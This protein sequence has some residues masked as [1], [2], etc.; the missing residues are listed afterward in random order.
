[1]AYLVSGAKD[2]EIRLWAFNGNNQ[3]NERIW[4][5]AVLQGHT[6]NLC[7]VAFAPKHG[8]SI[9]SA[10]QDNTVK[11]WGLDD[12]DLNPS[13]F[14]KSKAS[15][16]QTITQASLT[17]MA[18]KKFINVVKY[19][20]N[21]KIIASASQDKTVKLWSADSLQLQGTLAGH[22]KNMGRYLQQA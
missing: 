20:P 10:A 21:D 16:P 19:S 2:F 17:V 9:V 15:A 14:D 3:L 8:R 1:M 12:L 22:K 13:M 4:C 5:L 11:V 6:E 7:S 18:H